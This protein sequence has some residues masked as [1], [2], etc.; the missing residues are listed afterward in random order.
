VLSLASRR[1]APTAGGHLSIGKT[2]Q[3][4]EISTRNVRFFPER[5]GRRKTWSGV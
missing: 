4:W 5:R 3:K 1:G 2:S